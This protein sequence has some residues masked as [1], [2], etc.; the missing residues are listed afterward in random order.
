[1]SK[2]LSRINER[3]TYII[4]EMS[5]NHAGKLENAMKIIHAA[6]D[7]GA[8]C[9]KI[10]TFTPDTITLN[11]NNEFFKIKN[12]LWKDYNLYNLYEEAYTPWE[13][14]ESIKEECEKIGLDFLSTPFDKSAVDFLEKINCEFYKIASFEL[15][16]I[17]LIE[18]IASKNKPIIISCGMGS[19]DEIQ[20]AIDACKRMGNQ[21]I[22]L[23]KCCSEYPAEWDNMHLAN[24]LDMKKRFKVSV[25]LSDHSIGHL[26]AVSAV[27]LGASIIEKHLC[28]SDEIENPDS[29]FSMDPTSFKK[30][31]NAI[32]DTEKIIGTVHYGPNEKEKQ[33]MMF[34]RS[35]F[36][37]K[38]IKKGEPFTE[39]N[40]RSIRPSFGL[41][42]KYLKEILKGK[43][44]RDI[45][46]GCP[47]L[48]E[49]LYGKK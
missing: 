27:S 16:D 28:L 12:G 26:A 30:M 45:E 17:P 7:A 49:D 38:N 43:A 5:A 33:N 40:V 14:Q 39:E 34:R 32:R 21:M 19:I 9:L 36:A 24:I 3:K 41:A 11:C 48:L 2:I 22:F 15:V 47:L 23:L 44:N 20:D 18:Y 1:M 13:W 46:Y 10:Q 25:G 31:V 4:A 35:L 8:D 6:K 42:P 29:K 37:V